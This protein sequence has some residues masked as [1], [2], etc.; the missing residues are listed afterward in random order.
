MKKIMIVDDEFLVRLGLKTT[1][2]WNSYGYTIAAEASNGREA[3]K[4]METIQPDVLITD[5]KMPVMD[6]LELIQEVKKTNKKIAIIIL[7]NYEDFSYAKKAIELGVSK[8]ILKS[9]IS[10]EKMREIL[11]DARTDAQ[12]PDNEAAQLEASRDKYMR[13]VQLRSVLNSRLATELIPV[14]DKA[15]FEDSS[16]VIAKYFFSIA[17]LNAASLDMIS[18][19]FF[20]S[21]KNTFPDSSINELHCQQ[22]CYVSAA[23]PLRHPDAA[24]IGSYLISQSMMLHRN[25]RQYFDIEL[26]GGFSTPGTPQEF[27]RLFS[28]AE[29]A[30]QSCYF[31]AEDFLN[32]SEISDFPRDDSSLSLGY[33]GIY[34]MLASKDAASMQNYIKDIFSQLTKAGS[35]PK[36]KNAF[37]DFMGI[38]KSYYEE[39]E[40][41]KKLPDSLK[42]DSENFFL[43]TSV[44]PIEDYVLNLFRSIM[45]AD[46]SGSEGYSFSIK[47]AIA[48]IEENYQSNISLNDVAEAVDISK[49]YLSTLFKQETGTNFITYLNNFRIEKAKKLLTTTNLKIY[50]ISESVGFM[51]PYY[52]SKMFKDFTNLSCKEFKDKFSSI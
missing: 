17:A 36:L 24:D 34:A 44:V 33:S 32:Y 9:E 8:Y 42:F 12:V 39:K 43:F 51:N 38:A 3:L 50:E 45:N 40:L 25:L 41:S 4:L 20:S 18:K 15:L 10:T 47:K 48:F 19:T 27:P 49:S 2:D 23:I 52:F 6:G 30:R 29:L 13:D 14:P 1:I 7:S 37:T 35:Y 11:M 31:S 16:Y 22:L 5:I 28:E 21:I 26:K 46:V